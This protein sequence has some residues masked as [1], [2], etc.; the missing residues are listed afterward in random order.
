M[1]PRSKHYYRPGGFQVFLENEIMNTFKLEARP[2]F[3][4]TNSA[5]ALLVSETP[6]SWG[7]ESFVSGPGRHEYRVYKNIE[8]R[9]TTHVVVHGHGYRPNKEVTS[10]CVEIV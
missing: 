8:G 4:S 2:E 7:I 6:N 9:L 5:K 10:K 3:F 1:E